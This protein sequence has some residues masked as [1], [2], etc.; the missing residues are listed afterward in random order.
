MKLIVLMSLAQY[1]D[2]V[3][4]LFEKHEI[5]IYSEVEITGHTAET[6]ERYGWWSFDK[7]TPIYSTMYF[8]VVPQAKASGILSD[9]SSRRDEFD[10]DHPPRAFQVDVE[11]MV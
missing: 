10:P 8:A 5:H 11:K 1:K 4:K 3:R 6:I 2:Q 7:D 9:I